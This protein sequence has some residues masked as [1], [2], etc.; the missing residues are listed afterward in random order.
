M[1]KLAE[2]RAR[3]GVLSKPGATI[4][5]LRLRGGLTLAE[6]STRSGLPTSTLSKLENDK[7]S[8]T[9]DKLARISEGLDLDMAQFFGSAR[10]EESETAAQ[11]RRSITRAQEGGVID[12]ATYR[13]VY[14]ATDLLH[15]KFIPLV[16][17]IKQRSI[18]E[19][20]ELIRHEGEEYTYVLEGALEFHCDLYAPVVLET[21]DSI[22]FDSSMG[23][24]YVAISDTPCRVLSICAGHLQAID[25][26]ARRQLVGDTADAAL[27]DSARPGEPRLEGMGPPPAR[28]S[29]RRR[30]AG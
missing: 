4:R 5:D 19:F 22:Y 24:A 3:A 21:G 2:T 7:M 25:Y 6:L 18:A 26:E 15:K 16:G 12:T 10:P 8:L 23:H 20:G 9:Y 14:H 30:A 27:A 13:H 11:G 1:S 17:E 29:P 28:R